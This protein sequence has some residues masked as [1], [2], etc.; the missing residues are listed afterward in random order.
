M[1]EWNLPPVR[2]TRVG[3]PGFY[4][5]WARPAMFVGGLFTNLDLSGQRR[6]LGDV[7]AQ[8][9]FRFG[10]LSTL[11]LTVST[12]AAIAFEDGNPPRREAMLSIKI[13]K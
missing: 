8:L 1:V 7:G 5:S 10:L 4:A 12:G 13:L 2:F 9:D 6:T 11:E 3:S